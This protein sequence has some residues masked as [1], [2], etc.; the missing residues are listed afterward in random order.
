MSL[1][2]DPLNTNPMN[3]ARGI[4]VL[5]Y[6]TVSSVYLGDNE[7]GRAKWDTERTEIGERLFRLK[8]RHWEVDDRMIR[9]A[10]ETAGAFILRKLPVVDVIVP[11]PP[12]EPRPNIRKLIEYMSEYTGVPVNF[13]SVA[14]TKNIPAIKNVDDYSDRVELLSGAHRV[15]PQGIAGKRVLLFDDLYRSGATMNSVAEELYS[16]GKVKSVYALA[17]TRARSNR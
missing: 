14:R 3:V 15:N 5:D 16:Q 17:I 13:D 4:W 7:H 10:A 6:H 9:D 12:S 8:Y 2:T 1:N 11:I